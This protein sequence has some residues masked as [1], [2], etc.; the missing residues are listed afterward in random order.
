ML[1]QV[2]FKRILYATDLSD[3]ARY[4]LAHAVSIAN[5]CK[6]ELIIL[7]VMAE[8]V[9]SE[10]E[11]ITCI[12]LD[13][14]EEIKKKNEIDA[15][16]AL[17]GKRREHP[18]LQEA[19]EHFCENMKDN[20]GENYVKMDETIVEKGNPAEVIVRVAEERKCDLIVMGSYGI[21][22]LAEA[23]I[24]STSRRVLK[25]TKIPVLVVRLQEEE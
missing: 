7:H 1:P 18:A 3:S 12:G 8:N 11:I 21:S 10:K 19:L 25:R 6:A 14:W 15:R 13:K 5:A 16:T 23:I 2:N 22:G 20:I 24:G 9:S 17:I 4:A